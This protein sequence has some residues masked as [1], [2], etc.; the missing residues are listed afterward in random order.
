MAVPRSR[1]AHSCVVCLVAVDG[2]MDGSVHYPRLERVSS[3]ATQSPLPIK[4]A[5]APRLSVG[6]VRWRT[7]MS[8]A[9]LCRLDGA[10]L[11]AD[12]RDPAGYRMVSSKTKDTSGVVV[13]T[14]PLT[15]PLDCCSAISSCENA[16]CVG[17]L[18]P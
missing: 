2:W 4:L 14:R 8:C 13:R 16:P 18:L 11:E 1:L 15:P 6:R 12:R 17:L 7:S 5:A 10:A 3:M 9:V